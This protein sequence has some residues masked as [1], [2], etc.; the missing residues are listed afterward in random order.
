VE[1]PAQRDDGQPEARGFG[2]AVPRRLA[3]HIVESIGETR[4]LLPETDFQ[5]ADG[6]E[7]CQGGISGGGG[8]QGSQRLE[9]ERR[10]A[11]QKELTGGF[12]AGPPPSSIRRFMK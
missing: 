12:Q 9:G 2:I 10:D 7:T 3:C 5:V 4:H 6:V 11:Q 1:G 8:C